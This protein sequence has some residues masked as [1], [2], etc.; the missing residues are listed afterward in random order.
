MLLSKELFPTAITTVLP[1]VI[2]KDPELKFLYQG[3]LEHFL[4]PPVTVRSNDC[5]YL[6]RDMLRNRTVPSLGCEMLLGRSFG[7]GREKEGSAARVL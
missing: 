4:L 5:K 2:T 7:K 6:K 3:T 1:H